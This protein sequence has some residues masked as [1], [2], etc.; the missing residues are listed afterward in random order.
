MW[1]FKTNANGY[2]RYRDSFKVS[3]PELFKNSNG[4]EAFPIGSITIQETKAPSGYIINGDVYTVHFTLQ[5][6]GSVKADKGTWDTTNECEDFSVTSDEQPI[7][8]G[9][10]ITKVDVQTG[11]DPQ[12]GL[13]FA[14]AQF[15]VC[16]ANDA[17]IEIGGVTYEPGE[18][19]MTLITNKNGE[20]ATK[21]DALVYG[22]YSIREVKAPLGY[23]INKE[24]NPT[25]EVTENNGYV[26][27]ECPD[28]VIYPSIRTTARDGYTDDHVGTAAEEARITDTVEFKDLIDGRTYELEGTLRFAD[29]GDVVTGKDGQ[30][31]IVKKTVTCDRKAGKVS[32]NTVPENGEIE[33]PAFEFD[34]SELGGRTLVVT[35][36][37]KDTKLDKIVAEHNNLKDEGQSVHFVRLTT[38][39]TDD[40]TGTKTAVVGTTMIKDEVTMENLIVGQ[41]Y[42]V[43]GDLV[44]SNDCTDSIG[45]VHKKGD[46]IATHDAVEFV[47]EATTQTIS[48]D[49]EV[50]SSA[51]AGLSGVV[52]E[53]I[54]HNGVEIA[55][56]HD[57]ES[58]PQTLNWPSVR[59]TAIDKASGTHIG[60]TGESAI[61]VDSVVL[62][63]L[64]E[65]DS[66]Y[67]KGILMTSDGEPFLLNGEKVTAKSDVFEADEKSKT[68]ELEYSFDATGLKGKS[69]VVYEKLIFVDKNGKETEV[70]RHEDKDDRDQTVTFPS[71]G[72][73]AY[74]K[75]SGTQTMTLGK[76]VV[77]ADKVR[78]KGLIPGNEYM[79]E[80]E[81]Y[82]KSSGRS[83]GITS[84]AKF[85]PETA[86]GET[87]VEFA[88]NTNDHQGRTLVVFESVFDANGILIAEHKDINSTE[89]TV[90]VPVK[91]PAVNTGD[92]TDLIIWLSLLG[93]AIAGPA[94]ILRKRSVKK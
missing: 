10:R 57:F 28:P 4:N 65:G 3:G 19:V 27:V 86:D 37:L 38:S 79:I 32:D 49:Y 7:Y 58:V 62:D 73:M 40:G 72:T 41:K 76:N 94:V 11:K 68:F 51:L 77:M 61:I 46:V 75:T 55:K 16:N 80:G 5:E 36:T 20:C 54:W 18:A 22:K 56:H 39:A 34:A 74:D 92:N 44:Y 48:L 71:I 25:V 93:T 64:T 83:I 59:T 35:E 31:C 84:K 82:D 14:G 1:V 70:S 45:K 52:F 85:I 89:Q 69:L 33:M 9:L 17:A 29:T 13:S 87:I 67:I 30:P 8:G 66:Y 15:E 60:I 24:W 63:N 90:S 26:V 42:S 47:A 12:L 53:D 21:K 43:K 88:L 2:L 78:Y 50:D 91:P 23:E 81:I 6:D